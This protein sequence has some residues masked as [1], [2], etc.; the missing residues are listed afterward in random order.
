MNFAQSPTLELAT[1]NRNL[2]NKWRDTL[3]NQARAW[4]LAKLAT[5][6]LNATYWKGLSVAVHGAGPDSPA[7]RLLKEEGSQASPDGYLPP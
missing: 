5:M 1:K 2:L 4:P 3:R 6:R 7:V